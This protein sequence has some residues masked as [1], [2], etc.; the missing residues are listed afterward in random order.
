MQAKLSFSIQKTKHLAR[1]G[2]IT[3]NGV[4]LNTPCFMPVGTKATMKGIPLERMSKEYLGTDTDIQLIL[5]NSY[6]L[7]LRPGAE[8]IKK[9]G[10]THKF[11]NWNKLIL[12]DSG[13]F[14]VFSL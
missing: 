3:L 7:Y 2:Q 12:T 8:I 9:A 5:N 13:G 14:Q 4:T 10:G 6:H 1:A 11:Q